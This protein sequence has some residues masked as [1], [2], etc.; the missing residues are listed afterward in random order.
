MK[1]HKKVCGSIEEHTFCEKPPPPIHPMASLPGR[2]PSPGPPVTPSAE[3]ERRNLQALVG[4]RPRSAPRRPAPSSTPA[5]TK[6]ADHP[7]EK[8]QQRRRSPPKEVLTTRGV[9]IKLK[10][11]SSLVWN[12][13]K[14]VNKM[15]SYVDCMSANANQVREEASKQIEANRSLVGGGDGGGMLATTVRGSLVGVRDASEAAVQALHHHAIELRVLEVKLTVAWKKMLEHDKIINLSPSK[16]MNRKPLD[17][18]QLQW[19]VADAGAMAD[20]ARAACV[21]VLKVA[22][23]HSVKIDQSRSL[24]QTAARKMSVAK[25]M[26]TIGGSSS[27][28]KQDGADAGDAKHSDIDP[29]LSTPQSPPSKKVQNELATTFRSI[30]SCDIQAAQS[31]LRASNWSIE[32][33]INGLKPSPTPSKS[34]VGTHHPVLGSVV[35]TPQRHTRRIRVRP[36]DWDALASS[37]TDQTGGGAVEPTDDDSAVDGEL[38]GEEQQSSMDAFHADE[39][40]SDVERVLEAD[41]ED[42]EGAQDEEYEGAHDEEYDDDHVVEQ[43]GDGEEEVSEHEEDGLEHEAEEA[44]PW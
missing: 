16:G 12:T 34:P 32:D 41:W 33:A 24:M 26:G 7:A 4:T 27:A 23:Q 14:R 40:D 37:A 2:S 31:A 36:I 44:R 15:I 28:I 19:D 39:E 11:C 38:A 35:K 22:R 25:S 13:G 6:L 18:R 8:L 29:T 5:H 17:Q 30:A 42:D 20:E 9:H 43:Q 10:T 1:G 3:R 21:Q